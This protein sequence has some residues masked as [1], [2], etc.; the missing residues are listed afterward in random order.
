MLATAVPPGAD[1]RPRDPSAA[2]CE[3]VAEET[4]GDRRDRR[5]AVDPQRPTDRPP[6]AGRSLAPRPRLVRRASTQPGRA[7]AGIRVAAHQASRPLIPSWL[8]LRAPSVH[9][10][11]EVDG[12]LVG[13]C[14]AVEEPHRDDWV[15]T[16]LDAADGPMA[17]E[18]RYDLLGALVEE[19]AQARRRPLPRRVRRRPREPRAVRPVRLH[20][21]RPGGD[22]VA[23]AAARCADPA[24]GCA[25]I[26]AARDAAPS[27]SGPR[28]E[29]GTPGRRRAG[30]VAPV[31]PVDP[32]HAAGDRAHRGLRRGRLGVGRARGD[33]ARAR[34]STRFCTSARSNAWLLPAEQR[35]GGFAQHGS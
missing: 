25:P 33:R 21:L 11:A 22:L 35:A 16:E 30:R 5:R 32:R 3:I 10:V 31:R 6:G 14:R 7:G 34:R 12:E 28:P 27:E 2:R 8:P 20:G 23:C 17:A 26:V 4:R 9:L 18:I 24:R 19:G 29:P 1:R 13:S 15:I